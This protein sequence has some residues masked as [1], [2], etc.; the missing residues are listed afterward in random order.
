VAREEGERIPSFAAGGGEQSLKKAGLLKE[1]AEA[2]FSSK[3]PVLLRET[4]K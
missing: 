3:P 1:N 4:Q 2:S